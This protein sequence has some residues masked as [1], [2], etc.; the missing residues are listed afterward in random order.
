MTS[1]EAEA[2]GVTLKVTLDH[3][4]LAPS[5]VVTFTSTLENGR[6]KPVDYSI[7]GCGGVGS[8]S[9]SVDIPHGTPGKTWSGTAQGFKD[10]MLT[11]ALGAGGGPLLSP[12]RIDAFAEPCENDHEFEG[13]LA[14][15]ESVTSSLTWKP[16]IVTGLGALAGNVPFTVSAGYDRQ[17]DPPSY[18]PGAVMGMW[19]PIYKQLAVNGTL[20]VGG[21]ALAL[22][23]PGDVVDALLADKKF[24][25]WV[26]K[27]PRASWSS[28]N[29]FLAAGRTDGFP[30]TV[31]NWELDFFLEAGVPRHFAL[32]F[33][34]PFDASILLIQYCDVPCVE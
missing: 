20:A 21:E 33:V 25:K 15:G 6:T 32:A 8:L 12:V 19:A 3:S 31:P 24:V 13:I 10:Y 34:D 29:L 30:P 23:G 11:E 9:L 18:P 1:Y 5:E 28:A 26:E 2:D 14:P 17:N 22:P 16:E 27:E 4:V 7:P